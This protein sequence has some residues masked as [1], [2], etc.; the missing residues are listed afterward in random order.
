MRLRVLLLLP[1]LVCFGVEVAFSQGG[2]FVTEEQLNSLTEQINRLQNN[3]ESMMNLLEIQ[4]NELD[5][6]MN[7]YQAL[8]KN[9][10]E[11]LQITEKQVKNYQN[12]L[13]KSKDRELIYK[14]GIAGA[15]VVGVLVGVFVAK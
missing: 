15:F 11:R 12:L 8:E 3:N 4:K 5:L 2:Y 10:Q 13:S 7:D 6:Q 9:Y 1:L 14:Y